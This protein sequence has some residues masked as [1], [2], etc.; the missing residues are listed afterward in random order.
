MLSWKWRFHKKKCACTF[1]PGF[2]SVRNLR[3]EHVTSLLYSIPWRITVSRK[4]LRM[5]HVSLSLH[6]TWARNLGL[7]CNHG[8]PCCRRAACWDS[9]WHYCVTEESSDFVKSRTLS[10]RPHPCSCLRWWLTQQSE[11]SP[12][13]SVLQLSCRRTCFDSQPQQTPDGQSD[14]LYHPLGF[15]M[16]FEALSP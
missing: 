15:K 9:T 14:A 16:V 8:Y 11:L 5:I 12:T 7:C 2:K 10:C 4:Q 1:C 13:S 6:P 3:S